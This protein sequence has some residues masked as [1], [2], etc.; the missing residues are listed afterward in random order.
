[1]ARKMN[2]LLQNLKERRSE[3]IEIMLRGAH[4]KSFTLP[5]LRV[6]V[7]SHC[8]NADQVARRKSP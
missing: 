7:T 3:R 2:H 6:V 1:M 5:L 4:A 8:L